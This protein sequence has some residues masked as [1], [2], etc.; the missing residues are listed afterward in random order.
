MSGVLHLNRS[1]NPMIITAHL[2]GM[3]HDHVHTDEIS[4]QPYIVSLH[5]GEVLRHYAFQHSNKQ[6]LADFAHLIAVLLCCKRAPWGMTISLISQTFYL[7]RSRSVNFCA[8][9]GLNIVTA[10][11]VRHSPVG[12]SPACRQGLVRSVMRS[13]T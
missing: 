7:S 4:G 2:V 5:S 6:L 11:S 1:P 13:I 10:R 12:L 9:D 3:R 8:L